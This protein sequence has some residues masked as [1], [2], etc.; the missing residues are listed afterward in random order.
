MD[1]HL[2]HLIY[3]ELDAISRE[4]LAVYFPGNPISQRISMFANKWTDVEASSSAL[5]PI[6]QDSRT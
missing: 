6:S 4:M 3:I 5:V 1:C 2:L